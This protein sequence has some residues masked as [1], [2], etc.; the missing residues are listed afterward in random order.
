MSALNENALAP[1]CAT[2]PFLSLFGNLF[3][4]VAVVV[5]NKSLVMNDH[6]KYM[7]V[8]TGCHFYFSF[9]VCCVNLL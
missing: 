1:S 5:A 6:F 2:A 3:S 7:T 9:L 4:S 8:L